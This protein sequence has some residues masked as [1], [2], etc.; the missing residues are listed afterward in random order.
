V[1]SF[2][3]ASFLL[4]SFLGA[5]RCSSND[6]CRIVALFSGN[7]ILRRT[8]RAITQYGITK[9][10]SETEKNINAQMDNAK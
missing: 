9:E 6:S 1:L 3:S 2:E 5:T 8:V 7:H 10:K 4:G